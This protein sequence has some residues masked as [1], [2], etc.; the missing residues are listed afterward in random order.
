MSLKISRN[1]YD[2]ARVEF[3]F[4]VGEAMKPHTRNKDGFLRGQTVADV[5]L[6]GQVV[7]RLMLRPDWV[8]YTP[9]S[10]HVQLHDLQKSLASGKVDIRR[11][12]VD[13][14]EIYREVLARS[15]GDLI[16]KAKFNLPDNQVRTIYGEK[17]SR[18][19]GEG[20]LTQTGEG[21][22]ESDTAA[23]ILNSTYAIDFDDITA[24]NA[25][26]KLN[27]KFRLKTWVNRNGLLII[28]LPEDS[29]RTHYA[30]S[31]DSRVW[32]F[33]DPSISHSRE[34]VRGV[35]VEGPWED[36]PGIDASDVL[37]WFDDGKFADVK[38][39]GIAERQDVD[40]GTYVSVSA[41][42][43]KKD[44]LPEL[45]RLALIEEMKQQNAG[46]VSIDPVESGTNFTSPVDALPGDYLH[47]IPDDRYIKGEITAESGSIGDGNINYDAACGGIV[48]NEVYLITEVKHKINRDGSWQIN[49]DIGLV[50]DIEPPKRYMSYFDPRDEEWVGGDEIAD[51]GELKKSIFESI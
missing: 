45:A 26:A 32:R 20:S 47:M 5:C 17:G 51:N 29:G 18:E 9:T 25:I 22:I 23:K 40:R 27:K 46:S 33:K 2:F 42:E 6:N 21:I 49:A 44:A 4:E 30:A 12:K 31:H 15:S 41:T 39:V 37:N 16:G 48:R 7:Q 38:A 10:T 28:G 3:P 11:E 36:E 35:I 1:R 34:P 50:P 14:K 43:A 13:L 8:D 19:L 24:E